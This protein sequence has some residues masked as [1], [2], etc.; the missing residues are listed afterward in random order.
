MI[1]TT[2]LALLALAGLFCAPATAGEPLAACWR[3]EDLAARP[4]EAR[5]V[6]GAPGSTVAMPDTA[7]DTA[8]RAPILGTVRRVEL[9]AGEKLVAL[10]FDL[11]ETAGEIA[12]YDGGVVEALRAA[13]AR[14]TFFAGGHWMATHPER[15]AQLVAD[16]RFEIGTHSWS[17]RNLR[18][19]AADR[20]AG[21]IRAPLATYAAA[22]EALA[23][24]Q[25]AAG[26]DLG[27]APQ[28]PRLF[29]F[30]FGVCNPAA[31]EAV[32]EAGLVAV[33][34]DVVSGDPAPGQSADAIV[35]GVLAAVQPGSIV[36]AHAN[37]R[38]VHTAEALPRLIEGLRKK[39]YRLVTVGELLAAGTPVVADTCYELKPGDN[40]RY[41]KPA[42]A[43]GRPLAGDARPG[44]AS[45]PTG[46]R[47][48]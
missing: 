5:A 12:G 32:A 24:R 19:L 39:G 46:A 6:K 15:F 40:A 41:D 28:R 9:P 13:D 1:R 31:L 10:T 20:L 47:K 30:P 37:G 17:H 27:H 43:D 38:G 34:W 2:A 45:E 11:C 4:G 33:Q 26:L 25:C 42:T 23:A 3:A 21:E 22:R 16:P 36:V 48:P 18:K 35:R 44:A 14:A 29:R 7:A 8:A